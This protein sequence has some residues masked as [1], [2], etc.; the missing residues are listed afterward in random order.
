MTFVSTYARREFSAKKKFSGI[1]VAFLSVDQDI[2]SLSTNVTMIL[3][4]CVL[5]LPKYNHDC[6]YFRYKNWVFSTRFP[7]PGSRCCD[8]WSPQCKNL[9]TSASIPVTPCSNRFY[10][11]NLWVNATLFW[12]LFEIRCDHDLIEFFHP[13]DSTQD[14]SIWKL[15]KI[16][17]FIAFDYVCTGVLLPLS[18]GGPDESLLRE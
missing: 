4:G 13:R 7:I 1:N 2:W 5:T 3:G 14:K 18:P 12:I 15:W 16:A 11:F 6:Q 9:V 17:I 10:F 8:S